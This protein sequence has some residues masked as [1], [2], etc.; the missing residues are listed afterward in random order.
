M[1]KRAAALSISLALIFSYATNANAAERYISVSATGSVK[2]KPDTVRI[3]ATTSS[4]GASSRIA[5]NQTATASAQLRSTLTSNGISKS[6]I[7]SNSISVYPEYNYT[8]E[9]GSVLVGY[10]ASQN[11]EIIV[12][13]A[14]NAGNLVDLIV[15][16][17]GDALSIDSVTPFIYDPTAATASARADAVKRARAKANSYAKLLK[18][19]L[20][21]IIYLE[22]NG[23]ATPSPVMIATAKSDAGA[24]VVDLGTQDVIVS[25]VS[26]W[27][28]L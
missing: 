18:V 25:V 27:A 26:R 21:K 3:N 11:F 9:K 10:K 22:E 7:K 13:N 23:G 19:S 16:Q 6:Y 4:T 1:L 8:Q 5:L 20:G 12:R 14:A 15:G 24:T 28:I 2:V 17:V